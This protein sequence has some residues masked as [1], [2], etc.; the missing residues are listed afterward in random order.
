MF[1]SASCGPRWPAGA[2]HGG[3]QCHVS[4]ATWL[5]R[6][7]CVVALRPAG[8]RAARTHTHTCTCTPNVFRP[9]KKSQFL[10]HQPLPTPSH[11]PYLSHPR[12]PPPPHP[13]CQLSRH[14]AR[15]WE[16]PQQEV[17]VP[18]HLQ[19]VSGLRSHCNYSARVS[20][21]NEVG[22]S[23]FSPWL[24]F[25]TPESGDQAAGWLVGSALILLIQKRENKNYS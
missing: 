1:L 23:P 7:L 11:P 17:P 25:Q 19:V 12:Q 9:Q 15:R 20:C 16:L 10:H 5:Q 4:M 21:V 18:P 14:A 24:H 6:P 2:Q 13:P 3:R 22:A 8:G